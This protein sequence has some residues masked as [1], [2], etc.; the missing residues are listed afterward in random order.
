M[1]LQHMVVEEICE[2]DEIARMQAQRSQFRRNADWLESHWDDVTPHAY[3]KFIAVA[4]QEA[5]V[6]VT[7]AEGYAWARAAHPEDSGPLV[8]YVL[9]PNGPRIYANRW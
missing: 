2:A 6:A 8:E 5:F 1:E 4:G 9:P 7:S 3:G